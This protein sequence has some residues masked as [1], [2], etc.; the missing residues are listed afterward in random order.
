[1]EEMLDLQK[2]RQQAEAGKEDARFALQKRIQGLDEEIDRRVYQLYGL[3]EEEIKV[4][5]GG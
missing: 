3:T 2:Q 4:V 5:E 1:M